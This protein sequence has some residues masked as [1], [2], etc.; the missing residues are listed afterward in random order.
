M[1]EQ[2]QQGFIYHNKTYKTL[3]LAQSAK[4][5]KIINQ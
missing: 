5:I 1:D 2:I 4:I 3:G